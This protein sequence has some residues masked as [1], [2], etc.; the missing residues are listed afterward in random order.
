MLKFQNCFWA[1]ELRTDFLW[2]EIFIGKLIMN[3]TKAFYRMRLDL[4]QINARSKLCWGCP[5]LGRKMQE[6]ALAPESGHS[7][8]KEFL[9][10]WAEPALSWLPEPPCSHV[11]EAVQCTWKRISATITLLHLDGLFLGEAEMSWKVQTKLIQI[12]PGANPQHSFKWK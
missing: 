7:R 12:P 1:D 6:G 2:I 9:Q 5:W 11:W 3:E 10:A 8:G 4:G